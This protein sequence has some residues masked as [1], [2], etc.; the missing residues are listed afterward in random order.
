MVPCSKGGL[1]L[2][3]SALSVAIYS[4]SSDI[5]RLKLSCGYM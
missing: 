4:E 5:L 2:P 3:F 1:K